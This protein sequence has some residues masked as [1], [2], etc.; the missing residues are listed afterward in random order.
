MGAYEMGFLSAT[1]MSLC[2]DC[3]PSPVNEVVLFVFLTCSRG[4]IGDKVQAHLSACKFDAGTGGIVTHLN[5][6]EVTSGASSQ[7][8]ETESPVTTLPT[9][10]S[11]LWGFAPGSSR[12]D[13]SGVKNISSVAKRL[14]K[15]KELTCVGFTMGPTIAARDIQLSYNRAVL[16]CKRLAASI[17][18]VKVIKI[19][20]RQDSRIGDRIR[21]V[22]IWWR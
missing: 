4:D 7:S 18:G 19:E 11:M 17:P 5:A 6:L 15:A 22:E 10:K 16:V 14:A 9:R 13:S 21:R 2:A 12:L 1:K 8:P 20:G 3:L